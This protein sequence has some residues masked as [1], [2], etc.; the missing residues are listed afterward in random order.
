MGLV[1]DVPAGTRLRKLPCGKLRQLE[2]LVEVADCQETSVRRDLGTVE[3]QPDAP[4]KPTFKTDL[5]LSP[6]GWHP[7]KAV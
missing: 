7:R 3:L 2:A 5:S 1:A 6:I 4:V